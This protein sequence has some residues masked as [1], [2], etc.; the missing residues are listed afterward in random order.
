M[1]QNAI[2]KLFTLL[3]LGFSFPSISQTGDTQSLKIKV[4]N[5]S[6]A[7]GNIMIAVFDNAAD[8]LSDEVVAGKVEPVTQSGE[9]TIVIEDVPFGIYAISAFHDKN[10]N[11]ILDS[12]FFK[13]P[14]EPYGF[15]NDARGRFGPPDFEDA[16]INFSANQQVFEIRIK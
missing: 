2:L 15:S 13:I 12:N 16:R 9:I 11:E 7:K 3:F 10:A 8:F 1:L 5:I 6:S 14:T 4:S